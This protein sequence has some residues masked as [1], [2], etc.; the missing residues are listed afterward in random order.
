MFPAERLQGPEPDGVKE[1]AV[2]RKGSP[3]EVDPLE[4][5]IPEVQEGF[6]HLFE[7]LSEKRIMGRVVNGGET[8]DL[9]GQTC[10]PRYERAPS[11]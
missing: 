1:R 4:R 2:E 5:M 6:A 8:P 9:P 7:Q 11:H 3:R 10:L